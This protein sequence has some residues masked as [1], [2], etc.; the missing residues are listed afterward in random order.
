[1][2][3]RPLTRSEPEP[4]SHEITP[5][6][7]VAIAC[8]RLPGTV[9]Y[10]VQMPR[11]GGVY[12]VALTYRSNR[13]AGERNS[14]SIDPWSGK[15]ISADLV[16]RPYRSGTVHGGE[17]SGSHGKSFWNAEQDRGGDG[18]HPF[19]RTSRERACNVAAPGEN[20]A[21]GVIVRQLVLRYEKDN[22]G[23]HAAGR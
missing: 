8:A 20:L 5:D 1:M 17:R 11:Y 16:G 9:P 4:G 15:I 14:F 7:A 12:V 18:W 21:D 22:R 2:Q 3:V 6:Q 23:G 19:A 10:R 13:I